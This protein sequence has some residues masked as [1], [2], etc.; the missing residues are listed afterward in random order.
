MALVI[1]IKISIVKAKLCRLF[2]LN[3]PW[4]S[5]PETKAMLKRYCHFKGK[6]VE[7]F[8]LGKTPICPID[9]TFNAQNLEVIPRLSIRFFGIHDN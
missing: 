2:G 3:S 6:I 7:L 8:P 5:L 4:L 1:L 9:E